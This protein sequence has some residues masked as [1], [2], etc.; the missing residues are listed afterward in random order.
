MDKGFHEC[1]FLPLGVSVFYMSWNSFGNTFLIITTTKIM[2][3]R[4]F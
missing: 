3:K 1:K 2:R 4:N